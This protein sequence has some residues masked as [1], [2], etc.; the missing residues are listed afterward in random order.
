MGSTEATDPDR[1]SN[2]RYHEEAIPR[3]FAIAAREVSLAEYGRYLDEAPEGVVDF[4]ESDR[5]V[6]LFPSPDCAAGELTWYDAARYCNWLSR[7]EGLPESDWCYPPDI[8]PGVPVPPGHLERPGYRL[9]TEAEWEY[10]CRAGASSSRFYGGSAARLGSYAWYAG[11]GTPSEA[12]AGGVMHPVGT[13]MPNDLGLFDVLGNA[14][15][16]CDDEFPSGPAAPGPPPGVV[17]RAARSGAFNNDPQKQRSASHITIEPG[18]RVP[19]IGL[20]PA[21]TIRRMAGPPGD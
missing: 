15:E 7:R 21:R 5:V 3:S 19:V 13:K 18:M 10:A 17:S 8:G 16:W 14:F 2:E 12:D 1:E 6:V 4:R 20:R 9:P 11:P